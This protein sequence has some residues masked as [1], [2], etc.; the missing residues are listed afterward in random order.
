M[1]II[2]ELN[3][4]MT[5]CAKKSKLLPEEFLGGGLEGSWSWTAENVL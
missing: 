5:E 2:I 3:S 1:C 4:K